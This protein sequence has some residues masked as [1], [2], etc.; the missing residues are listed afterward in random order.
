MSLSGNGDRPILVTGGA[1]QVG[2]ELIAALSRTATVAAPLR[3][4]LDLEDTGSVR[5]Y[6]RTL[7]PGLILNAAA[8]T[9]VDRA[10][11]DAAT[12]LA[13]NAEAP[14]VLAEEARDLDAAIIHFSTDYVFDGTKNGPYGEDDPTGP[15]QVYGR[16]K[17]IGERNVAAVAGAFIILRCSWVYSLSGT[18]FLK[19][20][21]RLREGKQELRIVDDQ[22]GAPTWA[23]EIARAVVAIVGR[24]MGEEGRLQ[25]FISAKSGVYH[26]S[27]SG[28]TTWKEF[29]ET[30]FR[31]SHGN[32][33]SVIGIST[34]EYRAPAA[35]PRNSVLSNV[36]IRREL[37]VVMP[38][39]E[40]QLTGCLASA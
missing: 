7:R 31:S 13:V 32:K 40:E 27:A 29:A 11:D 18:G 21:F 20:M 1:G 2:S 15:L 24:G 3:S 36:K 23:R 30:I 12:C 9:A 5:R 34:D 10:E 22:H 8:Y 39:W 19:T 28:S 37:G 14:R 38:S 35:R 16:S 4:E 17:E 33:P 25:D 6:L 26:L